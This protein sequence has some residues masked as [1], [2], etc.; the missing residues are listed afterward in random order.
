MLRVMVAFKHV[1]ELCY[2]GIYMLSVHALLNL[3]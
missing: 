1:R 2:L 3:Y